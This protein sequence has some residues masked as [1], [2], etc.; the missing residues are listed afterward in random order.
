[1]P[2][3]MTAAAATAT[4]IKTCSIAIS[5]IVRDRTPALNSGCM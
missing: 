2:K 5:E 3:R 1:M 4:T